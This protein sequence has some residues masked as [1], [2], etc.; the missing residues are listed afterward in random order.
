MMAAIDSIGQRERAVLTEVMAAFP[1]G[2]AVVTAHDAWGRPRG[3]TTTAVTS[4]SL[5]PPLLLVCV[6]INSRTLPAIRHSRA[7]AVN[8][9][10]SRHAPVA[11]HFASKLEDKF[12][13]AVWRPGPNGLP[14]LHQHSLAWVECR[15]D[16]QWVAGDHVV[17]VGEVLDGAA[18]EGGGMPLTYFR[19]EFGGFVAHDDEERR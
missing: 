19:R 11:R 5:A 1:A 17:V 2:V 15:V 13:D 16:R 6:D 12:A 14:V 3:L 4:V 8:I 18:I 10:E 7:F 9:I